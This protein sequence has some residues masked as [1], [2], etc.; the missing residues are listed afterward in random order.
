MDSVWV[1]MKIVPF[2]SPLGIAFIVFLSIAIG[3][4][5]RETLYKR[6]ELKN[7]KHY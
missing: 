6:R 2:A 7:I 5:V 1:V 4:F 3:N